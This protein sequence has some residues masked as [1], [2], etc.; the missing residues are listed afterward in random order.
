MRI[1]IQ[2]YFGWGRGQ[3]SL[4]LCY[5]KMLEKDHD[6]F[7]LKQFNN[8]ISEDF[9]VV[10]AKITEYD[11]YD[12]PEF[13]FEEWITSNKLD[14]VIFNEYLQWSDKRNNLTKICK[15]LGVKTIG[16]LVMEKFKLEQALDYDIVL[17]PTVTF[18][19]FMRMN[20]VR[21]FRYVPMSIDFNEF[22]KVAKEY[23]LPFTFFHPG[24]WGGVHDRKNTYAVI[25][26]FKL[27]NNEDARLIVSSQKDMNM[28]AIHNVE[29]IDRNLT[30]K[31]LLELY[32]RSHATILPSKW[33]TIGIPI[34][35]SLASG[36]PVITSNVPPMNE[37]IVECTNGYLCMGEPKLYP[38][39]SVTS[40]EV[41]PLEIK[42]KMELMMNEF[43]YKIV[44]QN[45]RHIAEQLYDIEKTKH[46]MLDLIKDISR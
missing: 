13:F 37:F 39:I 34:L 12:I 4:S 1:G 46:Y 2:S 6:V 45:S 14:I 26:A 42:K 36:V 41:E 32:N 7:I 18:E 16:F 9:K 38:D 31:E 22:P 35:E 28:R 8:P 44:Q 29:M 20:R 19:R 25:E 27:L 24:G 3:A 15:K 21:N 30:R 10:N 17:A 33:E 40:M 5:V 23:S 11:K 43:T